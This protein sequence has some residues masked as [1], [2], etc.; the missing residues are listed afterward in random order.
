[1]LGTLH[2]QRLALR[3]VSVDDAASFLDLDRDPEV[4]R[5]LGGVRPDATLADTRALLADRIAT[6]RGRP[7]L[8]LGACFLHQSGEFIGWFM[9]RP[10]SYRPYDA[11]GALLEPV[12]DAELGYR[13]ARRFWGCG[14]ATE[15]STALV[16][17]GFDQL[18][19]RHIVAF[20]DAEHH[21]SVRVLE[22]AG[23]SHV[24]RARY[25]A[26]DHELYRISSPTQHTLQR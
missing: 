26:D 15:M 12:E 13:L 20:V 5:F 25:D 2:S 23:L 9:L 16:R 22:K 14:Y 11:T 8:G 7:G 18:G 1:M 24:G 21:A 4:M 17:H 6:Y 3:D 19:L 10:R